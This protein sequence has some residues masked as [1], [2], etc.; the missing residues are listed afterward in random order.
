MTLTSEISGFL[1]SCGWQDASIPA[2][3][4]D[5]PPRHYWRLTKAS[6]DRAILVHAPKL[7]PGH[8]LAEFA[9]LSERLR[10]LG[11][12][13]PKVLADTFTCMLLEDFGDTPIDT[14]QV[15]HEAYAMAVDVLPVLRR[16]QSPVVSYKDGYI[17]KKL[18]LYSPDPAWM[19]AWEKVEAALPPPPYC[20]SHMDYK[21]G[22]LHWLPEREGIARIGILDFQ[23]AQQAPFTYD[24]VNLLEDARRDVDPA[25]KVKLKAQFK[26]ALP[27]D[28]AAVFD[29]WYTVMAAQFHARVLGQVKNIANAT[30]DIVPRLKR[31]L[32]DELKAPV[33]APV[34][35]FF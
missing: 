5:W 12:S 25:L 35:A 1:Q 13:T 24:I 29:D 23:A 14:P 18:A 31:Y 28:W 10:I 2:I 11:L 22:N 26:T 32:A 17:Y 16:N 7:I 6:G 20:F 9:R 15:E 3:T 8:D 21:A 4:P 19:A 27:A 34:R 33:L 30:D